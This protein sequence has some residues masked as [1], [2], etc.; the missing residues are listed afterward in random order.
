M[1][2]EG[3]AGTDRETDGDRQR[4]RFIDGWMDG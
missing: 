2:L 3:A 1:E 4:D